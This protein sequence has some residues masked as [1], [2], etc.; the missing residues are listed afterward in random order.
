MRLERSFIMKLSK[1]NEITVLMST[2]N[3]EKF[4]ETQLDSLINQQN[5]KLNILVRDDGSTDGTIAI[6]K[7]YQSEGLLQW[8]NGENKKSAKSFMDLIEKVEP[9]SDYYA[10]CDQDDFWNNDKLCRA[11]SFIEK[12]SSSEI[13][14][15]YSSNYQLV[16]ENLQNLSD[17]NHVTT[18]TFYES[19]VSSC[20]TG[21]T[22]VFNK[23]LLTKLKHK[24]P[25]VIVMHDDWCHKVCLA[26]GGKVLF[27]DKKTL[28]YRQH[29][30]NVD[31]GVHDIK[32]RALKICQR[33]KS[34]DCIRSRQ[35][36]E[37]IRL[38]SNE[39]SDEYLSMLKSVAN[40]RNLS[41]L[42]RLKLLSNSKLKTPYNRLNRGFRVAILLKYF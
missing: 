8:Y 15:I 5:V 19:L 22:M 1:K 20:C 6:L 29:S 35:L 42:S 34:K 13:P 41:F 21:C 26:L 11:I 2:Y 16:D 33:I 27:D 31:G 14:T 28:L 40:Y 36:M 38:Y 24:I 32:S 23:A 7:K 25:D 9:S 17:N 30:S 39:I 18:T 4:L 37:I 10:F 12:N 3:G